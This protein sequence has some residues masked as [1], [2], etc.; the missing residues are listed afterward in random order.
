MV[1]IF[2]EVEEEL[3]KDK[4]ADALRKWGP[5][6]LGAALAIILGVAGYEYWKSSSQAARDAAS[7]DYAVALNA[8]RDERVD[9]AAAQFEEIADSSAGGYATLALMERGGLALEAGDNAAAAA[10]FEAA[11][12]RAPDVI[13]RDLAL[14]KAG[15]ARFDTLSFDDLVNR[16]GPLAGPDRPFRILAR[17]T[18]AAK[19]LA[20]GRYERARNDYEALSYSLDATRG[21]STRAMTALALLDRIAPRSAAETASGMDDEPAPAGE[22]ALPDSEPESP[23]VEDAPEPAVSEE[24]DQ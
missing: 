5:W 9:D 21:V 11:A 17:E 16:L 6:V 10:F 15:W 13:F 22:D 1:D 20:D 19:A 12:E 7:D 24:E 14:L 4:Y 8:L 2:H 3:R 23:A 18:I